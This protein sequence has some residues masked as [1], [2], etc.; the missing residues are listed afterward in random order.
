M[1]APYHHFAE[2]FRQLGLPSDDE[3]IGHFIALHRPLPAG[4]SLCDASFWS[5]GQRQFLREQIAR[6]ADWAAVVDALSLSLSA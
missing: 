6:D 2:L 4:V 5:N 3:A 1:D